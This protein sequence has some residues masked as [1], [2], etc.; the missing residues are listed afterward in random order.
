MT[1]EQGRARGDPIHSVTQNDFGAV[2][3]L[4]IRISVPQKESFAPLAK[5][6]TF[7]MRISFARPALVVKIRSKATARIQYP[8]THRREALHSADRPLT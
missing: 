6:T 7:G 4:M 2:V 1:S 3:G 8:D 5:A